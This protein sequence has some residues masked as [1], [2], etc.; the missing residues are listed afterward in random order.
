MGIKQH[1]IIGNARTVHALQLQRSAVRKCY[2]AG[3]G[4]VAHNLLLI[5]LYYITAARRSIH[6][7]KI[8]LILNVAD[9]PAVGIKIRRIDG[10]NLF[11]RSKCYFCGSCPD[12]CNCISYKET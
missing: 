6:S 3:V 2:A 4:N 5:A 10:R 12:T 8:A 7:D 1:Q 9:N 11:S